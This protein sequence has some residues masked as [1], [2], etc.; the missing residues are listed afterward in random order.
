M[1]AIK[2]R[3]ILTTIVISL[4]LAGCASRPSVSEN[5]CRA[6]DWESIG[7]RDGANGSAST[8]ILAHQEACGDYNIVPNKGHYIAGWKSG[9]NTFC[10]AENGFSQGNM[11]RGLSRHCANDDYAD[12][13][14]NGF[15]LHQARKAVNQ[16]AHELEAHH[17]RLADIKDEMVRVS[18]AQLAPDLTVERRVRLLAK[19]ENLVEERGTLRSEIPGLEVELSEAEA[20]LLEMQQQF[21]GL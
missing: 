10:T 6:G 2:P 21:A 19:L 4:A 16:L 3:L 11:G 20:Y 1:D 12:A 5:Q 8:R 15:A 18:S 9:I 13:H 7:F 17:A 14:A